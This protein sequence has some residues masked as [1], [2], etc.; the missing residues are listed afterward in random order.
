MGKTANDP[1]CT[2]APTRE[3]GEITLLS[4]QGVENLDQ[5]GDVELGDQEI[6]SFGSPDDDRAIANITAHLRRTRSGSKL[7]DDGV[8][9]LA[10]DLY[11]RV[12]EKI[13]ANR[14]S[15][16]QI[17]KSAEIFGEEPQALSERLH[18]N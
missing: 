9:D 2:S 11:N 14:M 13:R 5:L 7:D 4:E 1:A 10:I 17:Q 16:D 15:W 18:N 12:C 8:Q 3:N 6:T